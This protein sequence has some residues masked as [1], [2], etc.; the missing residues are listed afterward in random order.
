[1]TIFS[2]FNNWQ[3]LKPEPESEQK[4][5]RPV[6]ASA[7]GKKLLFGGSG[8]GPATL[9]AV[10]IF[11]GSGSGLGSKIQI[12]ILVNTMANKNSFVRTGKFE[13]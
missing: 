3:E 1:M 8:T 13:N 6:A 12:R 5:T 9:V 2:F 11:Y 10:L 7:L 4:L